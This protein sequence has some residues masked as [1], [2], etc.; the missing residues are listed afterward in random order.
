MDGTVAEVVKKYN[1]DQG[2]SIGTSW[3]NHGSKFK[4]LYFTPTKVC[5]VDKEG[6][7]VGLQIKNDDDIFLHVEGLCDKLDRNLILGFA[8]HN[9]ETRLFYSQSTDECFDK[10][11]EINIGFNSLKVQLPKRLLNNGTYYLKFFIEI[12]QGDI[13]VNN[14][15]EDIV[16]K[17]EINGGLSD[18]PRWPEV[19]QGLLA[20]I[21]NWK[22]I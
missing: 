6:R 4:N 3:E 18:S 1:H 7:N 16:L 15:K 19:R 20:P 9:E 17:Y 22:K 21:L 13:L 10:W 14:H 2:D 8:L 11:P 12:F 5:I